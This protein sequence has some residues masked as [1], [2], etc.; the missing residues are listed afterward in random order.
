MQQKT[1]CSVEVELMERFIGR[2]E[3]SYM[4]NVKHLMDVTQEMQKLQ[5]LTICLV[6]MSF[7]L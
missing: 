6:S 3:K 2:P 1:V 5:E 7:I 4:K